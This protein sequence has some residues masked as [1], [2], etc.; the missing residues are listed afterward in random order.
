MTDDGIAK[1]AARTYLQSPE[2]EKDS[3]NFATCL[4]IL[5]LDA[6]DSAVRILESPIEGQEPSFIYHAL[7]IS[8]ESE[9]LNSVAEDMVS[10]ILQANSK[11]FYQ[12]PQIHYLY[13]QMMKVPLFRIKQWQEEV[14]K[15]LQN[16]R[17][18]HR[19]LFYSLTLSHIERP[20]LLAQACLFYVRNW[21]QEFN[22]PKKYWGYFI[23][24]LSHPSIEEQ[25]DIKE[26]IRELCSQMLH[27]PNC[28]PEIKG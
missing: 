24:S 13:L 23:R 22:Q 20:T 9:K 10:R 6:M 26:E 17:K 27:T 5:G 16:E 3:T 11:K 25:P 12:T 15:V 7:H 19:N 1:D 2:P 8:T 18:I 21:K 28:P 14:S 4:Y